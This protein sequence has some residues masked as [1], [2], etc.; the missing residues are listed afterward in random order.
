MRLI[1]TIV[2]LWVGF[3]LLSNSGIVSFDRIKAKAMTDYY[4]N[5][6]FKSGGE[7]KTA[8]LSEDKNAQFNHEVTVLCDELS[9]L[10]RKAIELKQKLLSNM[11][12]KADPGTASTGTRTY[13]RGRRY[14]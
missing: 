3:L 14:K 7:D 9:V 13:E 1:M 6:A 8:Q 4:F 12:E 11:V 5:Q 2:I 10:S